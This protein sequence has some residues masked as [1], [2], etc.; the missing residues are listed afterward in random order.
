MNNPLPTKIFIT[1]FVISEDCFQS[2]LFKVRFHIL[3]IIAKANLSLI[4]YWLVLPHKARLSQPLA[5][6]FPRFA[7][8]KPTSSLAPTQLQPG[9]NLPPTSRNLQIILGALF[10]GT[11][12]SISEC[13]QKAP[14]FFLCENHWLLLYPSAN[15]SPFLRGFLGTTFLQKGSSAVIKR[16]LGRSRKGFRD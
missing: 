4:S 10:K 14:L 16:H 6:P 11:T 8:P 12:K 2:C 15:R 7:S 3:L 9:P 5:A 1:T 13:I